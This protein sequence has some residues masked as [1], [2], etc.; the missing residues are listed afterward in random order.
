MIAVA[1][2]GYH[3]V[4]VVRGGSVYSWGRNGNASIEIMLM[5]IADSMASTA[6]QDDCLSDILSLTHLVRPLMYTVLTGYVVV[7]PLPQM[8]V[9]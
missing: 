8:M 6:S 2:G 1:C 7:N 5:R 3:T 9:S 4:C